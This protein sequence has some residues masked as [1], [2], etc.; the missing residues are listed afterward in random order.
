MRR[1]GSH[2][3]GLGLA[4]LSRPAGIARRRRCRRGGGLGWHIQRSNAWRGRATVGGRWTQKERQRGLARIVN[5]GPSLGL[6]V[7]AWLSNPLPTTTRIYP[8]TTT[9]HSFIYKPSFFRR[10]NVAIASYPAPEA[11]SPPRLPYGILASITSLDLDKLRILLPG[12]P[13]SP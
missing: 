8:I 2:V 3:A 11:Q 6:P 5:C 1:L 4:S 9:E 7:N 12:A 13:R 10:I